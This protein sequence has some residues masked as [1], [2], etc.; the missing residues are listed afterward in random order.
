MEDALMSYFTS[1]GWTGSCWKD[2]GRR[3]GGNLRLP[4]LQF[5]VVPALPKRWVLGALQGRRK[6]RAGCRGK[7]HLISQD[8]VSDFTET[9]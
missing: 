8:G 9:K 1:S 2:P 5:V 3:A 4:I 7:K 6:G